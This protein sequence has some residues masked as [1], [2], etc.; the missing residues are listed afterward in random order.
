[1]DQGL[2]DGNSE[3]SNLVSP[4]ENLGDIDQAE[5]VAVGDTGRKQ[6]IKVES[7]EMPSQRDE[8]FARPFITKGFQLE[9]QKRVTKAEERSR[10]M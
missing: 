2:T 4:V 5:L 9:I 7:H 10:R 1:M 6:Q 8:V 3:T